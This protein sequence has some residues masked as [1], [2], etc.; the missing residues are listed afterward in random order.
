MDYA[1]PS[2]GFAHLSPPQNPAPKKVTALQ[3]FCAKGFRHRSPTL[4]A[5]VSKAH[6]QPPVFC[7]KT[8]SHHSGAHGQ[9]FAILLTSVWAQTTQVAASLRHLIT[10]V[11]KIRIVKRM[12]IAKTPMFVHLTMKPVFLRWANAKVGHLLVARMIL[13]ALQVRRQGFV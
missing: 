4:E 2:L 3:A 1:M 11:T 13:I 8:A 7:R 12:N 9:M 5:S 10:L 6:L